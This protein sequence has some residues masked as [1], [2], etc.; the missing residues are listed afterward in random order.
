MSSEQSPSFQVRIDLSVINLFGFFSF[1]CK[2]SITN[3]GGLTGVT[4]LSSNV[5]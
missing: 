4:F 5:V 1:Q 3:V 2:I